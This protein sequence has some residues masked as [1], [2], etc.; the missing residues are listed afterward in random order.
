MANLDV[1]LIADHAPDAI[2]L[3]RQILHESLEAA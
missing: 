1:R 3:L 2:A